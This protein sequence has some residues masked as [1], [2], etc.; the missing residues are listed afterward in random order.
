V[1]IEALAA[2]NAVI[3]T[4]FGSVEELVR[5]GETGI[6]VPP[7]DPP[8]LAAAIRRLAADPALRD[9]LATAGRDAVAREFGL[10]NAVSLYVRRFEDLRS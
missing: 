8:A 1:I 3:T 7:R 6:L 4:R 9:R 2:G 10:E 5:D